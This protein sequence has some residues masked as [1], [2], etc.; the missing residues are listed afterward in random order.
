MPAHSERILYVR[1]V[2]GNRLMTTY[3]DLLKIMPLVRSALI[4]RY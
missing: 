2:L 3:S 4:R 1:P